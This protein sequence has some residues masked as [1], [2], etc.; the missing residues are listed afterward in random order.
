MDVSAPDSLLN[1]PEAEHEKP[2]KAAK[3]KSRRDS[4]KEVKKETKKEIYTE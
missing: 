3:R 2:D 4:K 1:P